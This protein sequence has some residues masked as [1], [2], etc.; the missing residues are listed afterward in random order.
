[1]SYPKTHP[2]VSVFED[3]SDEYASVSTS[4]AHVSTPLT[5]SEALAALVSSNDFR[6]AETLRKEMVSHHVPIPHDSVYL[7]AALHAITERRTKGTPKERLERFEA[8]LSL[9]PERH[10]KWDSFY[11]IRERIFRAMDHLNLAL[12]HRFGLVLASKGYYSGNVAMQ[13]V[14]TLARYARPLFVQNYLW[15]LEDRA[16]DYYSRRDRS[17]P[18]D[19]FVAVY[20]LAAR[21]HAT[22]GKAEAALQLVSDARSRGV[23]ISE[24][25]LNIVAKHAP[26]RQHAIDHIR[27]IHP[28]W[29]MSDTVSPNANAS[30]GTPSGHAN[31]TMALAARLRYLRNAF[32]SPSPPSPYVLQNFITS[33]RAL[34][35]PR[36]RT[37]THHPSTRTRA[38]TSLRAIAYR[39][40]S[41]SASTWAFAEMLHHRQRKEPMHVLLV[42][43]QHF[44]LV[45][46]PR[47]TVLSH[48]R[49]PRGQQERKNGVQRLC[50]PPYPMGEKLWPSAYHTAI[51]WDTLASLST[52]TERERLYSLLLAL[53]KQSKQRESEAPQSRDCSTLQLPRN[54]YD[55][56]HFSPFVSSWARKNPG[57]ALG[58]LRDM[59]SLGI[60]PGVVQWSIVARGY[61]QHGDPVIA[62]R[63]LNQL[64]EVEMDQTKRGGEDPPRRPSDVLLGT[65]TNV[66]R[67]LVVAG[68][69]EHAREIEKRLVERLGYRAGDRPATDA[70]IE[71][72]RALEARLVYQ[73]CGASVRTCGSVG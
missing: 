18:A 66:L 3:M 5:S 24:F 63:I 46:I 69:V 47:K 70:S 33:Y 22:A 37:Y 35:R 14:A 29:F 1:M 19:R 28:S 21:T 13:V 27:N 62:L 38:I 15:E 57:K 4:G 16:R 44:H 2:N 31:E 50:V 64:E 60:E 54:T 43:F 73:P 39:H 9:A 11:D 17:L 23:Q 51:V 49:G 65:Y 58:V 30:E 55:A 59:V 6:A 34:S 42:F 10:E 41:K 71:L 40:S 72:L 67:G 45:G 12:V 26:D 56:A 25:T 68:D 36:T 53:A 32:R 7:R 61:A 52:K 20:N 8:W 48:I